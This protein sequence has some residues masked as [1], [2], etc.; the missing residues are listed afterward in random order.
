MFFSVVVL[1]IAWCA[2]QMQGRVGWWSSSVRPVTLVACDSDRKSD[3]TYIAFVALIDHQV[4]WNETFRQSRDSQKYV[5]RDTHLD[6]PVALL[7]ESVKIGLRS[8]S[9]ASRYGVVLWRA[10]WVEHGYERT[11]EEA[12]IWWL[13]DS[14]YENV[15]STGVVILKCYDELP[16]FNVDAVKRPEEQKG[17]RSNPVRHDD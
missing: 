9:G 4:V 6:N 14:E 3:G 17:V 2:V 1:G 13:D 5:A 11:T 8:I 12:R 15:L 10:K 16:A 7:G